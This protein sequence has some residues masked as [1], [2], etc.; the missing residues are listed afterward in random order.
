MGGVSEAYPW[1]VAPFDRQHPVRG[2]FGDPRMGDG[3]G[4]S[5]HTGIDVSAPDG[6][7]V[8]AVAPGRVSLGGPQNVVVVTPDRNFGYWHVVPAVANGAHV[9]LHG[10][11]GHVAAGWGH[12]HFAEHT[13]TPAPQGT[14]WNPLR[15]GALTPF[16]DFGAP[17]VKRII[18]PGSVLFG[19]VALAAEAL[20]HPPIA[21]P[22]PWD[23]VPVTPALVRWRLLHG[24][25]AMFPWRVA[26][27][28]RVSFQPRVVNGSDARFGRVYAR[29]TRQNHPGRPGLFRYRLSRPLDTRRYPDGNYRIQVD[30]TDVRGNRGLREL[31]VA[32]DNTNPPV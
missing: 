3:G 2:F 25:R 1:P 5:F 11:L 7:P 15:R 8:Y 27:D 28:F 18:S 9:P 24:E 30:A 14:Y 19:L 6:A 12:V 20:D 29:G 32:I 22:P 23:A 17:V 21:P 10:L 4:D 13:R 26:A 31:P 16:A